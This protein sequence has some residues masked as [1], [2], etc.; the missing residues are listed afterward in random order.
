[1][2]HLLLLLV[3]STC[4]RLER[5][6]LSLQHMLLLRAEGTVRPLFVAGAEAQG[7]GRFSTH[8]KTGAGL[9]PC[10]QRW[11]MA[12]PPGLGWRSGIRVTNSAQG[13][14][15]NTHP[16]T[17]A[18][19][20]ASSGLSRHAQLAIYTQLGESG[21]PKLGASWV[22]QGPKEAYWAFTERQLGLCSLLGR[23]SLL[24]LHRVP[25][26]PVQLAGPAQSASLCFWRG[27]L[28]CTS[29]RVLRCMTPINSLLF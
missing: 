15:K 29:T 25:A 17:H 26:G 21:V 20:P 6:R 27:T 11:S 3:I 13:K 14:L 2:R 9:L 18:R 12:S 8:M 5:G 23:C 16:N 4:S 7:Q 10:I 1:M 28:G 24:G 19:W 22:P